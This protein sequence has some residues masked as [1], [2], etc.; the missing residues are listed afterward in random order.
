MR[1]LTWLLFLACSVACETQAGDT[2]QNRRPNIIK[3]D[4]N[5]AGLK[6]P[7]G[8]SALKVAENLGRAR[9][10]AV[11]QAGEIYVKLERKLNCN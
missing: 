9:H 10:S 11:N 5:N 7:S 3:P 1:K 8:F 6:L 4:S 2:L